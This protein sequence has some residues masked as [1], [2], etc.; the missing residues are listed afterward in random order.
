MKIAI[1]AP[2][3]LNGAGGVETHVL[4]LAEAMRSLGPT[5]DVFGGIETRTARATQADGPTGAT[6]SWRPMASLQPDHYHLFHT[7]GSAFCGR[8]ITMAANR[9]AGQRHVHTLHGVSLDYLFACRAWLN[10]RCYT[11]TVIEGW[12]SRYADHVIAVSDNIRRCARRCFGLPASK[13]SVVGNGFAPP[14]PGLVS[15]A[16]IR[17]RYGLDP[18]QITVIFV[19]RGRDPVKGTAAIATAMN[20][21]HGLWPDVRLLAVP[22]DGFEQA[23]WLIKTGPVNR[24]EMGSY[25]ATANIFVNASLN[26]GMPLTVIEAMAGGLPVAAA[27]VGGIPRL[28][29]HERTGL[30]LRQD[31]SDLAEQLGRLIA[32]AELRR[33]LGAAARSA[34][35]TLTWRHIARETIMVY[36]SL[37]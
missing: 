9:R 19:G 4:E 24:A 5:V 36:E 26:E 10:Y 12:C 6:G 28:I 20:R 29:T 30:L 17:L 16:E 3:D 27:P 25:Y 11:A 2:L 18:A 22:G 23:E 31:R 13:I 34:V 33:R 35:Q 32:D 21:L 1:C 14:M 8:F 7:H 15:A 37:W